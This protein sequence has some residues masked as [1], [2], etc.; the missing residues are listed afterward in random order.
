MNYSCDVDV[1]TGW[2]EA[3]CHGRW[4][5]PIERKYN[6]CI[7]FKRAQGQGRIQKIVGM[8]Q[9]LAKYGESVVSIELLPIGAPRRNWKQTLISD[10]HLMIR[11]PDWDKACA[12]AFEAATDITMYAE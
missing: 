12:L 5:Q 7:L 3:V 8:E 9:W 4:S 2:A 1:W 6:A 10:G 11:H